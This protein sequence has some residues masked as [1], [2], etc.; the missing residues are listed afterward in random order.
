MFGTQLLLAMVEAI[1]MFQPS[2]EPLNRH[3]TQ[4]QT[5][6]SHILFTPIQFELSALSLTSYSSIFLAQYGLM[7]VSLSLTDGLKIETRS[8]SAAT[9]VP[10][11]V[12]YKPLHRSRVLLAP[13]HS[14]LG[15]DGGRRTARPQI[16]V[17]AAL[18]ALHR[19]IDDK[20]GLCGF[21][22]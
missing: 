5:C 16:N 10:S 11:S 3:T 15:S 9:T 14:P 22:V 7:C 21:S 17:V 1:S 19:T 8:R 4:Y 20:D 12:P 6:L 2:R 13:H 18:S